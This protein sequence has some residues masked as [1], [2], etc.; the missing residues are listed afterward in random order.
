MNFGVW[1]KKTIQNAIQKIEKYYQLIEELKSICLDINDKV[2]KKYLESNSNK[3]VFFRLFKVNILSKKEFEHA[4]YNYTVDKICIYRSNDRLKRYDTYCTDYELKI[5]QVLE[6]AYYSN[7]LN[8]FKKRTNHLKQ[9]L[10]YC[11]DGDITQDEIYLL[12]DID[13]KIKE[14][15]TEINKYKQSA[16]I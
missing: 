1:D 10:T 11:V 6:N 7:D 2:Y 12:C 5:M 4:N 16:G 3:R 14:F 15:E 13:N 8:N 9:A